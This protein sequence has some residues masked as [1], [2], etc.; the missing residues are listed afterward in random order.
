[1]IKTKYR[2]GHIFV[3]LCN[4]NTYFFPNQLFTYILSLQQYQLLFILA[5]DRHSNKLC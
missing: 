1:M 5:V 3:A 4:K 2:L